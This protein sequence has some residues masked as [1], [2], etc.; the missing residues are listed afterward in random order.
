ME[1][2]RNADI[3]GIVAD[4]GGSCACGTCCGYF[5]EPWF[6]QIAAP[7]PM[8]KDMLECVLNPRVNARLTCQVIVGPELSGMIVNLP[9]EQV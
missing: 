4:C 5:D 3:P 7:G 6:S 2:A 8:E 1:V 9:P